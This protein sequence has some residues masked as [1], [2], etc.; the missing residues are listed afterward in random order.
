M[1]NRNTLAWL[2]LGLAVVLAVA[3]V[4]GEYTIPQHG[5]NPFEHV[6][7]TDFFKLVESLGWEFHLPW[8]LTKFMVLELLA[9][10]IILAVFIPLCRRLASGEPP[11]GAWQNAMESVLT[12]IRNEVARPTLGEHDADKYVPFLWTLFLF[13]LV[14]N[15]LG[16]IP[17]LGSPTANLYVTGALAVCSFVLMHG[18]AATKMGLVRYV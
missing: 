9:A 11:R 1:L 17:W 14:C 4:V 3:A 16:M 5:H 15:L 7:D 10:L 12:F 6:G 13:V 18:A 8:P 2:A